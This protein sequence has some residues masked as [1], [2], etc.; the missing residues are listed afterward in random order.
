MPRA[1]SSHD[2]GRLA[3]R[4]CFFY[5]CECP[6]ANNFTL[7]LDTRVPIASFTVEVD[8]RHARRVAE[9][10][11]AIHGVQRGRNISE[12]RN[13]IVARVA[14]NM[15][16]HEFR[17]DPVE[18]QPCHMTKWIF[19]T[20]QRKR[21]TSTHHRAMHM[22]ACVFCVP[23][24]ALVCRRLFT[25]CKHFWNSNIPDHLSGRGIVIDQFANDILGNTGNL[26]HARSHHSGLPTL[27]RLP[28]HN[29]A[30]SFSQLCRTQPY[31]LDAH[32][33]A[34]TLAK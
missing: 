3:R 9:R 30:I 14:V 15:I 11:T 33:W 29:R 24:V 16:N 6:E 32:D 4:L 22:I 25:F 5:R 20:K 34:Q 26:G 2:Q 1:K 19:L 7:P 18:V 21:G 10:D 17:R 28:L 13:L 23:Y 31:A 27:S 8:A 12:I